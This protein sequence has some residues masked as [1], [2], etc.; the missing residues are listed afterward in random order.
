VARGPVP[1]AEALPIARQIAEALEAAH[2]KGI[3]HRDLKPANITVT[4]DGVVKV[5]DFGLAKIFVAEGAAPDLSQSPTV[6]ATVA[7]E[8]A[9]MGT[10]AYMSPEQARGQAVDKRTDIWA[11]GCVLYEMLTGRRA[12]PGDDVSDTIAG[13]LRGEADWNAL[14]ASTPAAVRKLLRGC[15][16]KDRRERLPD[17]GVARLEINEALTAPFGE[18]VAATRQLP[19]VPLWRR[20]LAPTLAVILGGLI[21][22]LG[23]WTLTRPAPPRVTRLTVIPSGAA[24]GLGNVAISPDG[25]RLAYVGGADQQIFVRALDELQPTGLQASAVRLLFFSP[26]G[27]WIGFSDGSSTIKKVAVAGGPSVVVSRI[28]TGVPQ[29]A[30]WGTDDTIV[31]GSNGPA[32]GLLRVA[33]AGG[34]PEVL[35]TPN[36]ERGELSHWWPEVLPDGRA[37]LFTIATPGGLDHA[38]IAVLDLATREQKVLIRGGSHARYVPTGHLVYGVAGALRAVAFDLGR[39]EVVGAP[40]PVMDQV[41]TNQ[42][43]GVNLSIAGDGTLIY[44]PGGVQALH[45][46]LV[47][48]DRQGREEPL[49]AP[50]RL[51]LYPR[52]SPDGTR[53]A[54]DVVAEETGRDIW[55]WDVAR[56]TLM[57]FTFDPRPDTHP[58]WTPDGQ[59]VLFRSGRGGP[60]NLFWQA[61]DGTGT[62]ERLTESSNNQFPS[63]FSPDGTRLVFREETT[64]TGE[65]LMVLELEGA[66]PS[67]G[68]AGGEPVEP[69]R[70]QPLVQTTFNELNAEISPDG[71]WM[72]YQSNE[73]GKDE[74]YVRPFP[75]ADRGR[76]QVSAGGGTRPLWA[77]SGKELFYAKA[78]GAVMSASVDGG[79]TFRASNPTQLFEGPYLMAAAIGGRTYDVSPDGRRFLMIKPV[80]GGEFLPTAAPTSLIIV[81]NWTEEL[82]RLVPTK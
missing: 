39:L 59:R 74:I 47:W 53:V 70:A 30:S 20:A 23:V 46:T 60:Y 10:V 18:A 33:A 25:T 7:R 29:G 4:P 78:S 3:I 80:D 56:E 31:F 22:G 15:L 55:I 13:I 50:P 68:S 63:A 24:A 35:T 58:L 82:K 76:W 75:D 61:A 2:E 19:G 45:S 41:V 52:L 57:R 14:P 51:Y 44:V 36:R 64:K 17:I 62:V 38:Q 1:I 32:S 66:R 5:L 28:T 40:V 79:S 65:D 77:R 26:D 8:G 43:G 12:F 81:Q 6:T 11:F 42:I 49:K 34:E 71:R 69:R 72:A 67:S 73:S 21:V 37:V 48:V 54:L 27:Q 9:M 16:N